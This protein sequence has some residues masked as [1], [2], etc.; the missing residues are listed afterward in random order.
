MDALS[1]AL[2]TMRITGALFFNAELTAPW[3]FA[4]PH[5]NT[6]HHLLAPG[7]EH[8]VLFHL[9]T[10]GQATV[11][12][13]GQP[14]VALAAGD[15]VVLPHGDAHELSNGRV[16]KLI[17]ATALLPKILSGSFAVERGGGGG[18][19]TRFVCGYFGCERY[20]ERLF[21]AGLPPV[22][23]V[24]IHGDASGAW[25]EGSLR[26]LVS[27][28]ESAHAGRQALVSKLCEALF[29][30]TLC[31]YME[32]LP[33]ERTGWLAAARDEVVGRTLAGLH[34]D[35]ARA[36]TLTELAHE[37][38]VSRTVLIERFTHFLGQPPLAYLA[39]WRL[40][41]AARL[42]ET[43]DHSALQVAL[44][45]GYESEAAFSRAFKRQFDLPPAQYRRRQTRA[46]PA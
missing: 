20:A 13:Q 39:Q 21:L 17:D 15:I 33:P 7:T 34:R 37:A 18:A 45:V 11:R 14:D 22:F 38:C 1:E 10:D 25:I 35:P 26:H 4:S 31:R 46:Q 16:S 19:A 42:L 30:Q 3:G 44:D 5:T 9:V 6:A 29:I 32:E 28:L 12:V 2:R 40:Q 41:L 8:L 23:K 36:W 27:E 24:N 43:T